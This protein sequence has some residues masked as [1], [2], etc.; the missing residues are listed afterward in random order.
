MR[1]IQYFAVLAGAIVF[2]IPSVC[3]ASGIYKLIDEHGHVTYTNTPAKG[4]RKLLPNTPGSAV[5]T[6]RPRPTTSTGATA[7]KNHLRVSRLQQQQR[8]VKRR[9][10]LTQELDAEIRLLENAMKTLSLTLQKPRNHP[11]DNNTEEDHHD[12]L[13]LRN[14]A[15]LHERNIQALKTELN[16]L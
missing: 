5:S 13:Q 14:Q 2:N 4:A 16:N 12:I 6:R 15:A 3:I 7:A 8:D 11:P 9:Q 10:I 1:Q